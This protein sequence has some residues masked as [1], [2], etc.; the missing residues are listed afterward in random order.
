MVCSKSAGA[1]KTSISEA[2]FLNINLARCMCHALVTSNILLQ[3]SSSM[4][5]A[6]SSVVL[7]SM[8][9]TTSP[10]S[11]NS[12]S[13][14]SVEAFAKFP[15]AII[16]RAFLALYSLTA[17]HTLSALP[18]IS[19]YELIFVSMPIDPPRST[20]ASA[21][22]NV[23][24]IGTRPSTRN[25]RSSGT[26]TTHV[27]SGVIHNHS[28]MTVSPPIHFANRLRFNFAQTQAQINPAIAPPIG[29]ATK[30]TSLFM[31]YT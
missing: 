31:L 10:G 5:F 16:L 30:P 11:P 3:P 8:N 13:K 19:A 23:S 2:Y 25:S 21:S 7:A 9:E 14:G 22:G 6:S 17:C 20:M 26:P 28:Q 15:V 24:A 18:H 1:Q 27:I 29:L 12:F 4:H